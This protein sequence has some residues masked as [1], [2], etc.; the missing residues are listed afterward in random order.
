VFDVTERGDVFVRAG[1]YDWLIAHGSLGMASRPYARAA[2]RIMDD[3]ARRVLDVGTGTGAMAITLKR[4]APHAEIHGVDPS[5][6]MLD[7]ARTRGVRAGLVMHFAHGWGQDLPFPDNEFDVV[8]FASVLHHIPAAQRGIVLAEAR[9]VL[10]PGARVLIV[11]LVPARL[12]RLLPA[13]R[14]QMDQEG[15]RRL[16]RASG[17]TDVEAGRITPSLLGYATGRSPSGGE[18]LPLW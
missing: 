4:Q 15:C 9:R 3:H 16:L 18:H 6:R 13:H 8:T 12:A 14:H 2:A 17:F 11:E 7:I 1:A 5:D 10:R